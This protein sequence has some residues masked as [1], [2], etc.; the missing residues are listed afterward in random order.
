[1]SAE[2]VGSGSGATLYLL[3]CSGGSIIRLGRCRSTPT[4]AY[5][6]RTH[7]N[8]SGRAGGCRSVHFDGHTI[9]LMCRNR[10][11]ATLLT[12]FGQW[13]RTRKNGRRYTR[14]TFP[15]QALNTTTLFPHMPL[16][17][18]RRQRRVQ[19]R[20]SGGLL[21]G[22]TDRLE[23]GFAGPASHGYSLPDHGASF[24]CL[25]SRTQKGTGGPRCN[26]KILRPR[27]A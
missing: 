14:R 10:H 15:D 12:P 18:R 6:K 4:T 11:A 23:F 9:Q 27:Q 1:V 26:S 16:C 17:A 22:E 8:A 7:A 3:P 5:R 25:S 19:V 20:F 21:A 13:S 2:L 24:L